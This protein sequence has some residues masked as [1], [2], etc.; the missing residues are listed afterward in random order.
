LSVLS[1]WE[2]QISEH[3]PSGLLKS[4]VFHGEGRQERQSVLENADIVVTTFNVLSSE[5]SG[6][7]GPSAGKKKAKGKLGRLLDINW[8]R[9]V[10]DEGHTIRNPKA[11]MS[12]YA[13]F[14]DLS[15]SGLELMGYIEPALL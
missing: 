3:T 1:N 10:L 8:K 4:V 5:L 12:R 2:N 11:A 13:L 15:S 14:D 6:S 7:S 9:V